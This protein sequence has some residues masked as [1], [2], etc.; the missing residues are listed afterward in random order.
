MWRRAYLHGG[1]QSTDQLPRDAVESPSPETF[2]A[3]L[4]QVTKVGLDDFQ[5]PSSPIWDFGIQRPRRGR[6]ASPP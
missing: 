1:W 5:V 2:Q 3:H 4:L 6:A